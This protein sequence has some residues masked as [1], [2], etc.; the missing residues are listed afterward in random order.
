MLTLSNLY[1]RP[2]RPQYGLFNA[3]LFQEMD[4]LL[5]DANGI[6]NICLVPE[7]RFWRWAT[8]RA[9]QSP[10]DRDVPTTYCPVFYWPL[11]GRHLAPRTYALSGRKLHARFEAE[12]TVL[13]SWLYPDGVMAARMAATA[14]AAVWV[15]VLGT[16]TE[17]LA[18]PVRRR[19]IV[20]ASR[21]IR[22][23]ICVAQ[24]LA[25]RLIAA[26]IGADRISVVPNGVNAR[27]F[28]YRD[29]RSTREALRRAAQSAGR[30]P[31]AAFLDVDTPTILFVGN[32]VAVKAPDDFL[33][34]FLLARSRRDRRDP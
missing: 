2:D 1:P 4:D 16:D 5:A 32:L 20:A 25:D 31:V 27:L 6:E 15:M 12:S 28:H 11:I 3:Q 24:H 14:G 9:W 34:A 7:W 19:Q 13:V 10:D 17:H 23:F 18:H 30:Q 21:N 26:G 22:G 8:I 33:E 29:G